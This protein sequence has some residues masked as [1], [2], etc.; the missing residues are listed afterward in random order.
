MIKA[1]QIGNE[2]NDQTAETSIITN[3]WKAAN[4]KVCCPNLMRNIPNPTV[5]KITRVSNNLCILGLNRS[6]AAIILKCILCLTQSA[7]PRNDNHMNKKRQPS[8]DQTKGELSAYLKKTEIVIKTVRAPKRVTSTISGKLRTA[9]L[10]FFILECYMT[11]CGGAV[12][13]LGSTQE[14]PIPR[15]AF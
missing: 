8:S 6:T 15:L 3:R 4:F 13:H 11:L 10:I 9:H 2:R 5:N 12:N 7:A 1:P 14:T